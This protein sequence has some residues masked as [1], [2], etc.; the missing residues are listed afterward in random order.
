MSTTDL[1]SDSPAPQTSSMRGSGRRVGDSVFSY[2]SVGSGLLIFLTLAAVAIFLTSESMPAVIASQEFSGTSEFSLIEVTLPLVY[3]TVLASAIALVIA[4]PISIGIALFISHF[5]P[6]RLAAGLGYMIDLLAAV[7]SVVYG[8]WGGI[9]LVPKLEPV[10]VFLNTYFGWI[11]LFAGEP[12]APMRNLAS[13]SVVLAVMVL[14]IITAVSREVFLQT[15]RLQEEAALA[16]GAT[17]WETIR[18]VVLPFGR[19]G[20]VAASMLGLG[21]ALGETMAV[22]MILA[23]GATFSLHIL[24]VGR[25]N[26]IAANIASKQAEASG[27]DMSLLIFTGL[28][29]FVLTFI[30]N[31]LARWIVAR[32]G[33][34]S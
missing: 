6:R 13:A 9:W 25:H 34:K 8:L 5:A 10:Y 28:V 30:I 19:G 23:P 26:S 15:P 4:I 11:P 24:E 12:T 22:L 27:V 33:P 31:A 7:P 16:L 17:R 32:S 21:R 20:V 1:E 29:L 18:T 2:L 3:G 14:P